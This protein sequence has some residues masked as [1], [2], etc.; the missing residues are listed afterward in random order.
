MT[1][2]EDIATYVVNLPR[3]PDRRAWIQA[4]LPAN[5]PVRYTSDLGLTVDGHDLT[6]PALQAAGVKLFDWQIDSDNPWWNRPLKYGE[7]G[8]TLTHLACW[9]HAAEHT[10]ASYVA[11]LE[12][13]AVLE[14]CF[15][16]RLLDGLS[17][18]EQRSVP[19]D[20][21]YLGRY[22]LEPDQ[23]ASLPGFANP[24][25]SHCSYGYLL[26]RPA[27][28]DLLA[29]GLTEAV[30]PVDEFLPAMYHPHPR[31]DVHARFPP[32]LTALAFDPP[33]VTQ[34]PKSEAGSDTEASD[35][36]EP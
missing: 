36:V 34:R 24:G 17:E 2:P 29:M 18:L 33:L 8:C 20:L 1:R 19:F 14:S 11:I 23:P 30:I 5:L 7:I 10:T 12:D 13:D 22:P 16:D 32:H 35:F 27:L 3:R 31:P 6:L 28:S 25:Y 26:T 15:L 4:Q 9:M 21:L